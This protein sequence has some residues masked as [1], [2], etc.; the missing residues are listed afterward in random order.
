MDVPKRK[1]V[2]KAN[3][4]GKTKKKKIDKM[5]V[6]KINENNEFSP[7]QSLYDDCND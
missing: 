1:V 2:D 7:Y 4:S 5:F 3:K 6:H